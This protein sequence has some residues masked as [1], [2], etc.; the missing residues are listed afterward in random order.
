MSAGLRCPGCGSSNIV[1][2]D[3]YA[4]TQL[5]CVDCG[6]V[7]AEGTLADDPVGGSDVSYSR[8]TAVAKKPCMNLIKGLQR[9]KAICRSLRVHSEI[10]NLSQNYFNQAYQHESF[11]KVSL[12]KKEVLAGCCVLVSCRL[13]NWPIT[14]GTISCLLDA[15]PMVVGAIYQEMV[16]ILHIEAPTVN[17][18]DV[19]EAHCQEYKISSLHVPEELAENSKDLTKRAVALVELAAD[20]WI[21]TGRKPIP[22][23]MAA[24]FLG[25][26]SLKPNKQR[27]K[28]SLDKFCQIAKVNKH[29]P[30]LK[31]ITEIKEVLCKL[32]KEIPW[33]R[34][35]V[36]PDNVVLQVEDIL[37]HR[38]TLLRRAQRTHEDALLVE[39]QESCV[40][41]EE[42]A[43]SHI[44]EP[45]E[46][47]PNASSVEQCETNAEQAQQPGDKDVNPFTVP[48]LHSN[49]QESQDPAPN[50]GKRV[51]FAPPCVIHAKRRRLE[52]PELKDVTGDEEISDS[53]IESYIRTPQEIRDFALTQKIL[54]LS[55]CE[56]S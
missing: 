54:S 7:V 21:V 6:Y 43:P 13:L 14:T 2:D 1:D 24:I 8:T 56:K 9:V 45:V 22:I 27:L 16:K 38:Y 3:L 17:I 30:A 50:W 48:E 47:T 39:C 46:Q 42:T 11:L 51:L 19:M 5:V 44:S 35:A 12:Q 55:E 36:T 4:Q 20:A 32:G 31:R 49:T 28:F 15:D 33:L 29:K 25:W 23:M 53:E 52:Q 10:E 40:D 37:Q 41:S 18:T 34:E 26:Q